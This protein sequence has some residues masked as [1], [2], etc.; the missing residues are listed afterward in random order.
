VTVA[1]LME[2]LRQF[3][4]ETRVVVDGYE[5]G[6]DDI[7]E[8]AARFVEINANCKSRDEGFALL[9]DF[10]PH[11]CGMGRHEFVDDETA[12]QVVWL[13]REHYRGEDDEE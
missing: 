2:I 10:V 11:D 4:P 1:D 13:R 12:T 7:W 5:G 6:A 9:K 3:P 8:V